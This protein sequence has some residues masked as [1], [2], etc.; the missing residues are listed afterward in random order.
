[1]ARYVFD[2][3]V[4]VSALLFA[5]SRPGVAFLTAIDQGNVLIS[6]ALFSELHEV[7]D[8]PK[9]HRYI[10]HSQRERFLDRFVR[11]AEIVEIRERVRACRD[12]K[13]DAVLEVA[14]NGRA[15]YIVTGDGDLL[16]L[17]PFRGT[18][19]LTPSDL[20]RASAE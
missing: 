14:V 12:P 3:N 15:D 16:T 5:S 7:L 1:M 4:L 17:D 10:T 19:I 18:K 2:T 13:D 11:K 8:R 20:V 9:F 6:A